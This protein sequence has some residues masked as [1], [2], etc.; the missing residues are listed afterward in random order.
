M[1]NEARR[2]E[3]ERLDKMSTA[4]LKQ[5]FKAIMAT[6]MMQELNL[7]LT[8]PLV[9]LG[10]RIDYERKGITRPDAPFIPLA[11]LK[12]M[13]EE[14]TPRR[15]DNHDPE[16]RHGGGLLGASHVYL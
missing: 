8:Q 7:A 5:E 6:P 4:E 1:D 15:R 16:Q 9:D 10:R 13:V 3:Q 12:A 2:L 11:D 14:L